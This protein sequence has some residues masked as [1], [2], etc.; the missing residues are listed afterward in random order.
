MVSSLMIF[1]LFAA[2]GLGIVLWVWHM[3]KPQ[4]R[5]PMENQPDRN[6]KKA[7]D[8]AEQSDIMLH[9]K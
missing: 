3:R 9:R 8:E 7:A 5:H 2:L 4:N 1:T 6:I